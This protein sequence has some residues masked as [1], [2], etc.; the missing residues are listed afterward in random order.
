MTGVRSVYLGAAVAVGV[1]LVL[2]AI[3]DAELMIVGNDQKVGWDD[4]GKVVTAA[5]GR[6]RSRS[7]TSAAI[8]RI[9]RSSP[10]SS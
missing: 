7:S 9:R 3:A 5:P 8:R 2:P 10:T 6:I 4:A 1:G